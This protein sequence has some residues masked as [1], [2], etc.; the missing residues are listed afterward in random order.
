MT[1]TRPRGRPPLP[2]DERRSCRLEFRLSEDERATILAATGDRDAGAWVREAA[3]AK[4]R[5]TL[6]K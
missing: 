6:R 4:A 2:D 3:L 5:R 1:S